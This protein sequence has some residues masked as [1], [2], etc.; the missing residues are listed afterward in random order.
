MFCLENTFNLVN[1]FKL[2][3]KLNFKG[4]CPIYNST[5]ENF[6]CLSRRENFPFKHIETHLNSTKTRL[7]AVYTLNP[8][9]D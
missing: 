9:V 7:Y 2:V 6:A 8:K 5:L 1:I 3:N 4:Q